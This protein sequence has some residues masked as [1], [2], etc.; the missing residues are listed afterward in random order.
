[1][2]FDNSKIIELTHEAINRFKLE[3]ID[4]DNLLVRFSSDVESKIIKRGG[5]KTGAT[6]GLSMWMGV[7]VEVVHDKTG[8]IEVVKK[9]DSEFVHTA[10]MGLDISLTGTGVVVINSAGDIVFNDVFGYSLKKTDEAEAH[11]E[12]MIYIIK[13][14]LQVGREYSVTKVGIENYAFGIVKGHTGRSFQSSSQSKLA[15]LHGV[16]KTQL[17]MSKRIVPD[18]VA[19]KTGRKVVFGNG[20]LAKKDVIPRLEKHGLK[21][22]ND[23]DADAFVIAECLRLQVLQEESSYGK[24][25]KRKKQKK[26]D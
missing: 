25:Q 26:Q 10:F 23:N 1:M 7:Q 4:L 3:G 6:S 12:R 13:R 15:E 17:L 5:T 9:G 18:I 22:K 14:I 21:F 19:I 20:N 16:I 8:V 11:I 24:S 2:K